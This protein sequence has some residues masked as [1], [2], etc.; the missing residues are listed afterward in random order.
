MKK[1]LILLCFA[2]CLGGSAIA[3]P[4]VSARITKGFNPFYSLLQHGDSIA[5]NGHDTMR[6]HISGTKQRIGFEFVMNKYAGTTDTFTLNLYA[7][8]QNT[9]NPLAWDL[10]G[11]K[12]ITGSSGYAMYD[13]T[14]A[15][16]PWT[17]YMWTFSG[18]NVTTTAAAASLQTFMWIE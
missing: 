14:I 9:D 2:V 18:G 5:Y 6:A 7:N 13:T 17:N 15:G 3:Q 12:T 1:V 16:N 11:S 10:L 4:V 8:K